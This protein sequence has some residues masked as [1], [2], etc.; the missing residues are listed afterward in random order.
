MIDD[1]RF[2]QAR[3]TVDEIDEMRKAVRTISYDEYPG[4]NPGLAE[5]KLRTYMLNGT[6]PEE[7]AEQAYKARRERMKDRVDKLAASVQPVEP[8]PHKRKSWWRW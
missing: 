1:H 8:W 6:T 3:Y 2:G 7:L 5:D 4:G